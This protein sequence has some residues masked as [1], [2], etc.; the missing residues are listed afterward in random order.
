MKKSLFIEVIA[1][2]FMILF[3]YTGVSKLMD[4]SVF[5][6]QIGESPIL[7]PIASV[8]AIVLP[9]AEF[10]VAAMLILPRWRLRG[11]WA[12]TGLMI[13]FTGYIVL[14][15]Q[16]SEHIPCSCGGVIAL[17]SWKQHIVFNS[18][19]ILLGA[20]AILLERRSRSRGELPANHNMEP[21][22]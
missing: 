21:G 10:V 4:Y 20:T 9:L 13:L 8:I 14:M 15:L 3:L 6:E 2:L 16:F 7:E 17:L 19:F 18:L 12:S 22:L 11:L 5:K 1:A